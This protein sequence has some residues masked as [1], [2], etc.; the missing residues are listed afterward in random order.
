MSERTIGQLAAV[1]NVSVET[2]RYYEHQ[3]LLPAP[4]R[5]RSG[6]RIYSDD[7]LTRLGFIRRAKELGFGLK[8]I[9]DLLTLADDPQSDKKAV[10]SICE[11]HLAELEQRIEDLNHMR[12][13]LFKLAK[14]CDGRGSVRYCPIIESLNR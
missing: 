4:K 5:R 14:Q 8:E 1:S 12:Q 13:A 3:G 2:I 7:F 10:K 11:H 6:Y 9:R